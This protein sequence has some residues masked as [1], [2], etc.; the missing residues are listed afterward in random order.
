LGVRQKINPDPEAAKPSWQKTTSCLTRLSRATY[1]QPGNGAPST[2]FWDKGREAYLA[3]NVGQI[4]RLYS[5]VATVKTEDGEVLQVPIRGRLFADDPPAVG[6]HV[7][8]EEKRGAPAISGIQPR[9]SVLARRA[10]G[11]V[12][13]R[14]VLIANIDQVLVVFAAATPDPNPAMLDRFLVVAEDDDLHAEIVVNKIDLAPIEETHALFEPYQK[15]G[16][17]VHYTSTKTGQGLDELRLALEGKESVLVGPSGVGKSS[18]LNALY[19]GLDLRVGQVSEAYGTGRHTTVGGQ[20]ITLPGGATVADTAGLREL[21][22]W[23][24]PPQDLPHCFPEFRQYEGRCRFSDC[25]HVAEPGCAVRAA[26]E[27][28]DIDPRR[29]ESYV[30]LRAEAVEAYPRW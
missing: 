25:A 14:H 1:N 7:V 17:T 26:V 10:A 4:V 20:L 13:R 23:M 22:L 12:L 18:L 29:Y 3:G 8:L 11:P 28:G 21:G 30:K 19:P 24:I 27:A 6:D 9:R 5:D 15:A 16:Y 2:R